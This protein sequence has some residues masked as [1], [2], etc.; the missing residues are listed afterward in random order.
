[1]APIVDAGARQEVPELTSSV[2]TTV[3][4]NGAASS[5]GGETLSYLWEQ[6]S[7]PVVTLTANNALTPR[8]AAPN[9]TTTRSVPVL[10]EV[11]MLK[12]NRPPVASAG[13]DQAV[14]ERVSGLRLTAAASSDPDGDTSTYSWV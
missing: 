8:F 5:A 11:R 6:V 2:P 12:I 9:V 13:P 7:G 3:T 4:L 1:M 14:N 10:T